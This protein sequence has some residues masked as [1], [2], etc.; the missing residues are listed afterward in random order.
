MKKQPYPSLVLLTLTALLASCGSSVQPTVSPLPVAHAPQGTLNKDLV[1]QSPGRWFVEFENQA[2][3]QKLSA[4]SFTRLA[5]EQGISVKQ[6]YAY[7]RLFNGVSITTTDQSIGDIASLPGVKAV[8]PV[9]LYKLESLKPQPPIS[10][11]ID[12]ATS[13]T[14]VDVARTELGLTGKGIK[15]GIID[16]GIDVDH[17]DFKG[18][19]VAQKDFVGDTYN[20]DPDG[21]EAPYNPVTKPDPIADDCGGHG[22]HVAGI[23]GAKGKVTGVAPDVTFGAYKV[24]GCEGSTGD[25]VM[26][27][28]L[29]QAQA[30]DMDIINM[31]IGSFGSW[32]EDTDPYSKALNKAIQDGLIVVV[33]AGNNGDLGAFASGFNSALESTIAV[34]NFENVS[35]MTPFFNANGKAVSLT[36]A[37]GAAPLPT[38]GTLEFARTGTS[39]TTNDACNA[40]PAGSLKGKVALIRRGTCSF[41]IKTVNAQ[42]AGAAAVVIYNNQPGAISPTVVGTT[43]ITIPVVAVTKEDGE[44]LDAMIAA[45]TTTLEWKA[46]VARFPNP[47]ADLVALSSSYG[48]NQTLKFKPDLGAPGNLIYSTYPLEKGGYATLSGTSMAAPHVAGAI[49]LMLEAKPSLKGQQEQVR[50]LLQNHSVPT[51]FPGTTLLDSTNRQGAGIMNVA[52]SIVSTTLAEPSR[53]PLGDVE[54]TITKTIRVSNRGIKTVTY[55]IVHQPAVG[56]VGVQP[57]KYSDKAATAVLSTNKISIAPGGSAVVSVQITPSAQDANGTVFGGYITMTAA[58]AATLRVPYMGFKGD[59]QAEAS[60][61]TTYFGYID[62][63]DKEFYID[64][65]GTEF[66]LAEGYKPA[67]A[68][69]LEYPAE[70]VVFE[71]VNGQTGQPLYSTGSVISEINHYYRN[72]TAGGVHIFDWNGSLKAAQLKAGVPVTKVVPDGAYRIQ[73]RALR[74]AGDAQNPAH[75]DSW[76]SPV[77]YIKNSKN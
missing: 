47:R 21:E 44:K 31:S 72:S 65:E 71:L 36:N 17:P 39:S 66:N 26:L 49:A 9:K 10:P 41:H 24:F 76:T 77:F 53:L 30:D 13:Q 11:E 58:G 35:M 51:V 37:T 29:E 12:T 32:F 7:S 38:S 14:G 28:A 56:T 52:H 4:Q 46:G 57:G 59:Y 27:A 22:T 20:P 18:R 6:N 74:A 2:G 48:P 40:L 25:D 73:V 70:K 67:V 63:E 42:N 3:V 34:A 61:T 23:V 55:D 8:Y 1:N 64:T 69:H 19:I 60:L 75:W 68:F 54:G 5:A 16:S 45:G 50:T 43:P 33:S 15:V 62:P